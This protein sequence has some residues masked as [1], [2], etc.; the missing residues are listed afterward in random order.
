MFD[1]F[2]RRIG[3]LFLGTSLPVAGLWSWLVPGSWKRGD[4]LKQY[5]RYVYVA[6][7]AIAEDAAK[8]EFEINK[9]NA[10]GIKIPVRNHPFLEFIK[11][12]NSDQSQFQFLEFHFTYLKQTGESF[13]YL[14]KGENSKK[15][16]EA[17]LLRPDLVDVAVDKKD[18]RGLVS[19]YILTTKPDGTRV[20]F[21]K[22]E[23][24]HFKMPNPLNPY[25]GLGPV[26]AGKIYVETEEF[27][28]S[29]TRNSIFNSGRPSGILNFKGLTDKEQFEQIKR[30]FKKEY[31]GT[32]NAGKT[33]LVR[34]SDGLD[35][36]KLGM[37]L[38]EISLKELKDMTRDDI[39]IMFR[40]SKTILGITDD[41][42]RANAH[43]SRAVFTENVI[44]PE[45]DM[46]ITLMPS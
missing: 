1:K 30:Q 36:Q 21:E 6:V 25:R 39:M 18:S 43:E 2:K 28:S 40:V 13:W 16:K 37:E 7:S 29:F 17:Y 14:P 12:P 5:A 31:T 4:L 42:N 34:G 8:V 26:E 15:P 9:V 20:P 38:G 22:D 27:A 10:S 46:L 3:K 19:G 23:V 11:K 32:K 35:Y 24:L 44:K 45:L 41:V 33:L